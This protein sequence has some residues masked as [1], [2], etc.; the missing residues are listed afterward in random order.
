M[1]KS[2]LTVNAA[3]LFVFNN[4]RYVSV[5]EYGEDGTIRRMRFVIIIQGG[6]GRNRRLVSDSNNK[7]IRGKIIRSRIDREHC[8]R[9]H[10]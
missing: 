2:H 5:D 1:A 6:I 3:L 7:I 8:D 4:L 10:S 9:E